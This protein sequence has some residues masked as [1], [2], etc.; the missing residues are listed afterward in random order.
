MPLSV[1]LFCLVLYGFQLSAHDFLG[2]FVYFW[3]NNPL[4]SSCLPD[5][6]TPGSGLYDNLQKFDLPRAEAV[7]DIEYFKEK[8]DAFY[9]LARD[10][11]P[12]AHRP[13]LT[14][15]FLRLL[16]DKGLLHAVYTQNID[17]LERRAGVPPARL[18]E[19]HGT[20]ATARCVACTRAAD[21]AAVRAAVMAGTRPLCAQPRG[22]EPG[23][24]GGL[25]KPDVVFFGESL[26]Q[27]FGERSE[28]DLGACDL[29][30]VLGTSLAVMPFARLP[31]RVGPCVPRALFNNEVVGDFRPPSD[32][33][34]YRDV[35]VQ[36]A[37]DAGV[38]RFCEAL[39]WAKDLEAVEGQPQRAMPQPAAK[40]SGPRRAV[41]KG[42]P[43]RSGSVARK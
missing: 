23:A 40:P 11:W 35:V 34:N 30:L 29:L 38:R 16:A 37:C 39:G 6:R 1:H 28:A 32:A 18:V 27:G 21:P 2:G 4:V 3:P 12:G 36:G 7:F 19:C 9:C 33:S 43:R 15:R 41:A 17:G 26:P 31:Q 5:F 20:F 13:T 14:H 25:L 8:P 42:K 10:L 22:A 24:C